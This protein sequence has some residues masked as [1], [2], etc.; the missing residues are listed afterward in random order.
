M[1]ESLPGLTKLGG[2]NV[3]VDST[4]SVPPAA[5]HP[6]EALLQERIAIID[7]AMGTMIQR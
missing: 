1:L 2:E 7:G 6:F 5:L 3:M 4:P